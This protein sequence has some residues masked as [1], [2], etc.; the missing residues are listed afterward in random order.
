METKKL[1]TSLGTVFAGLFIA[2]FGA[3]IFVL[4]T[5]WLWNTCLVPAIE[6]VNEVGFWQALGLNLLFSILFKTS[7][8]NHL[9]N[10]EK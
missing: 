3:L 1:L 5:Y 6:G 8:T 7:S 10:K 2:L 9:S 4:P